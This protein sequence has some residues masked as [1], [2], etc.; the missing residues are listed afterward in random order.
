MGLML[1]SA[2]LSRRV[3]LTSLAALLA[4]AGAPAQAAHSQSPAVVTLLGDSISAGLGLPAAQSLAAQLQAALERIGRPAVVRAAA[5]SGDTTAGGLARLDFSVQPDTKVCVVELGAND[6]LQ[7]VDIHQTE[8]NLRAI[9]RRLKAR[10]IGVVLASARVP[11]RSA[12]AYGREFEAM[13]ARVAR[14]EGATLSPDLLAGVLGNP[15][16]LQADRLHPNAAGARLIAERLAPT[17]ARVL[18]RQV[19]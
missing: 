18:A 8:R 10:R 19:G 5:V 16:M 7:S 1:L 13:Y 4:A 11:W 15:A 2:P 12:G 6:F 3:A 14:S 17:V 9:V